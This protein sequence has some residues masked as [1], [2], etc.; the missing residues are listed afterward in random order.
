MSAVIPRAASSTWGTCPGSRAPRWIQTD[1]DIDR[2]GLYRFSTAI[3]CVASAW[4][5]T[6]TRGMHRYWRKVMGL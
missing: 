5:E 2:R 1:A 3:T 6:L 4:N